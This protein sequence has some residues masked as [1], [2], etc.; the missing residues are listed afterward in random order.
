MKNLAM[1]EIAAGANFWDAKGREMASSACVVA[2]FVSNALR[3]KKAAPH[4]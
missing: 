4:G 2:P 1:S 3:S